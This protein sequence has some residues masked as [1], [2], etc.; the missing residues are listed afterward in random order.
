MGL[1]PGPVLTVRAMSR[2]SEQYRV[3]I[4]EAVQTLIGE[5]EDVVHHQVADSR[6]HPAFKEV[7]DLTDD[8]LREAADQLARQL[9]RSGL[10]VLAATAH[11][12]DFNGE[13]R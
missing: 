12:H 1:L 2:H 5:M 4:E 7:E 6:W 8:E 3:E 10:K 13:G 11:D 9:M